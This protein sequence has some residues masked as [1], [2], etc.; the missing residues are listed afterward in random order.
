MSQ[1]IQEQ[2]PAW[3]SLTAKLLGT[4]DHQDSQLHPEANSTNILSGDSTYLE[5]GSA[6][7]DADCK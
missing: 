6:V 3:E 2:N 7:S 5:K 1:L 4:R